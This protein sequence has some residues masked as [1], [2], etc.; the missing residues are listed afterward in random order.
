MEG[1]KGEEQNFEVDA[2]FDREPAK[3]LK[4]RSDVI[5]GSCSGDDAGGRV[6]DQLEFTDGLAWG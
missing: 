3:L 5:N 4:D 6:L 1:L 2:C